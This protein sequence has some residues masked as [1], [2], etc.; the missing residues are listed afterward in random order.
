[1]DDDEY[2]IIKYNNTLTSESHVDVC[3]Y[4][5]YKYI[6]LMISLFSYTCIVSV[7]TC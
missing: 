1:M 4:I 3:Y 2:G 7:E 5:H 6:S